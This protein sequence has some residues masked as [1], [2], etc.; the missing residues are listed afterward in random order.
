MGNHQITAVFLLEDGTEYAP[1]IDYLEHLFK[2]GAKSPQNSR[3]TGIEYK[4]PPSNLKPLERALERFKRETAQIIIDEQIT[5]SIE[6]LE[7]EL[8]YH[9]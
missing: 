9:D 8:F 7:K 3:I 1:N 4:H 5:D 6:E 2:F